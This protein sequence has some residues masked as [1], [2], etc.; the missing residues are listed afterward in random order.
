MSPL[1]REYVQ[2]TGIQYKQSTV[3]DITFVFTE[4]EGEKLPGPVKWKD[5]QPNTTHRAKIWHP[6]SHYVALE[7]IVAV[8]IG[9]LFSTGWA[10]RTGFKQGH[11]FWYS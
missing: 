2:G 10:H 9:I 7:T 8:F 5:T 4:S 3:T 1:P 6:N 11:T